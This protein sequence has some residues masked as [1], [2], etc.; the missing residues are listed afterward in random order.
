[1]RDVTSLEDFAQAAAAGDAKAAGIRFRFRSVLQ[2]RLE[3]S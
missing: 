2:D 1:V 3:H